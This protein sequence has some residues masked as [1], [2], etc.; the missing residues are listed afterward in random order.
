MARFLANA[1]LVMTP[2]NLE[3]LGKLAGSGTKPADIVGPAPL[4]HHG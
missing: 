3:R 1:H 4:L 2:V